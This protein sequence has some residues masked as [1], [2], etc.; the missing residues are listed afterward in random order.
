VRILLKWAINHYCVEV[1]TGFIWLRIELVAALVNA[2]SQKVRLSAFPEQS[3]VG[4]YLF[5]E[6][7]HLILSSFPK[8][9]KYSR[10]ISVVS[11]SL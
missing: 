2:V 3:T 9:R 1:L 5:I 11:F 6:L 4:A 10:A 8:E 7:T